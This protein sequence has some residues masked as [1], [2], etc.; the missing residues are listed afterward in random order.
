MS[1]KTFV[2]LVVKY[3]VESDY[4]SYYSHGYLHEEMLKRDSLTKLD[5]NNRDGDRARYIRNVH[6]MEE[7]TRIN[8]NLALLAEAP[9]DIPRR[10]RTAA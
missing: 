6:T 7:V 2:P 4:P 1:L 9:G 10:Q 5:A 3:K 8:T